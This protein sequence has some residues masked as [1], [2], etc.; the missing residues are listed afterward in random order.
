[1]LCVFVQCVQCNAR[2]DE[3]GLGYVICLLQCN[4]RL[5]I[6]NSLFLLALH[7][8]L[9]VLFYGRASVHPKSDTL[10]DVMILLECI[11]YSQA[12]VTRKERCYA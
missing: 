12:I 10:H 1:M 8:V 9:G 5:I 3:D 4:L 11:V 2:K 7:H 6:A